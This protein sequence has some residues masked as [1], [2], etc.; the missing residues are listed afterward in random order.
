MVTF[1]LVD[2]NNFYVSCERVFNPA[3]EKC[4]V[5]ILS[6]NDGC[7][8]AR[9]NDIK[10]LVPMG[11]PYYQYRKICEQHKVKVLSANYSLYGSLSDKMMDCFRAFC[12]NIEV[13][14]IDEAFLRWDDNN[15]QDRV[16]QALLLRHM[17]KRW[18]GLPVSVGLAPTK[19]LAKVANHIA[20]KKTKEGVF[21][22]RDKDVQEKILADFPI[23]D[24]WGIGRQLTQHLQKR[25]IYTA[26][27][28]RDSD[29]SVLRR[30]FSVVVERTIYE[31]RGI[32]CL[33][34]ETTQPRKSILS[35]RSFGTPVTALGDLEEALS[36]YAANAC[37]KLRDQ[38]S[39]AQRLSVFL[40]TS[41]FN[42]SEPFYQNSHS[43]SFTTPTSDTRLII[44]A[45]KRCLQRIYKPGLRYQKTGIMLM[46][47]TE[48]SVTQTDL[49]A[50]TAHDKSDK[51]MQTVDTIN[52]LFGRDT[53]HFAAQ[54]IQRPWHMRSDHRSP[55]YTTCWD[56]LPRVKAI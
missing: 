25:G 26:K 34:L 6:N 7:F 45:A 41:P 15:W 32:A 52:N 53:V 49:F 2:G 1:S 20:K 35:S 12:P 5:G 42:Q 22:I 8:V 27:A 37:V 29:A 38:K 44:Q 39:R 19:T 24:I 56:E 46:D 43:C 16:E 11:A 3:L 10:K 23:E 36:H 21:D 17:V 47:V 33:D 14:S 4:G 13:Y 55:R 50:S 30:T 28:L 9:S 51:L 54:G 31:L 48:E 40:R 18:T